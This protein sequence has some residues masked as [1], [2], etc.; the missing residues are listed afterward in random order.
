MITRV[1]VARA[2]YYHA[3]AMHFAA[4]VRRFQTDRHFYPTGKANFAAEFDSILVN[5]A[6]VR[7]ESQTCLPR[8]DSDVLFQRTNA[9]QFSRTHIS[10]LKRNTRLPI[11]KQGFT[12]RPQPNFPLMQ[13]ISLVNLQRFSILP[14]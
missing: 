3:S 8:F 1:L 14:E 6:G 5:D 11:V 10:R 7:R 4:F 2:F 12:R 13:V 9:S